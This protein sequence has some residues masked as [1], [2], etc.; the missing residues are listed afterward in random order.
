MTGRDVPE[1]PTGLAE[2]W[3]RDLD[4]RRPEQAD[5]FRA[6]I[7]PGFADLLGLVGFGR[8][9]VRAQGL[10]LFD[11]AGQAYLDFTAG[12][13]VLNLGH[14]HPVVKAALAAT[15]EQDL[16]SFSQVECGLAAGLA[17]EALCAKLPAGLNR[18]FWCSSGSEAV[19]A[20]VKLARA[21]TGRSGLLACRGGFHGTT[22]GALGLAGHAERRDRFGPFVPG[23]DHVPFGDKRALEQAL[24][25]DPPA[26]F[27]LEPVQGEGGARVPP[28]G[29]LSAAERLCRRAGTLLVLD[30]V[31][32][33]LGR[34]GRLFGLEH[35]G[36]RPDAVCLAKALGGG[37]MPVGAMVTDEHAFA[38]AY[39]SM[40][41]CLDHKTTFSGGPLAMAAVRATLGVIE[42]EG[43]VANSAAMGIRLR[44]GLDD[45]AG[46][47]SQ[48][49][50]VSGQGLLQ[51]VKLADAA[52]G[53]LDKTPLQAL[54]VA[55][56]EL[57]AQHLALRLLE[58][59]QIVAQVAANDRSVLKLT[60][61]L[62][63]GPEQVDRLLEA[64][65]TVLAKGG[66]ARALLGLANALLRKRGR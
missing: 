14:N 60:P 9:Y 10:E 27:V 28:P 37:L 57:F 7:N 51:G 13:G 38:R 32:T 54:G 58:D 16:P 59:H 23:V 21:A 15:L 55:S 48:I 26:A 52:A 4:R 45:L 43:L 31:Q 63:V 5:L 22:L 35:A 66:H 8:R 18:V 62:G 42:A 29:Y 2:A 20:A 40:R 36:V 33:G 24:E 39:G 6:W 11:D 53:L 12:Y 61:P 17:A 64:L 19:E 25:S 47:S 46:R 65:E 30:E 1:R 44:R 50:A 3:V 41:A 49:A 34:T 56:A